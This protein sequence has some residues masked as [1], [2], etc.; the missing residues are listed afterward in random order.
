[1]LTLLSLTT[2]G[3]LEDFMKLT[4]CDLDWWPYSSVYEIDDGANDL[5]SSSQ[6]AAHALCVSV[7]KQDRGLQTTAILAYHDAISQMQRS[8]DD[9]NVQKYAVRLLLAACMCTIYEVRPPA[10]LIHG[11]MC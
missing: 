7:R 3:L 9:S 2:A 6:V 1:M 8:I 5:L 11:V 4:Q 10:A